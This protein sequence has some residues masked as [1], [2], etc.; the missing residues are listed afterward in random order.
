MSWVYLPSACFQEPGAL[1]L[2]PDGAGY[3]R[4]AMSSGTDTPKPSSCP[5]SETS[6]LTTPQYGTTLPLSTASLGAERWISSLAGF[7]ASPIPSPENGGGHQTNATYGPIRC[8]YCESAG[9]GDSSG[10]MSQESLPMDL[11]PR[12][13]QTLNERV[14]AGLPFQ[15][16]LVPLVPHTHGNECFSWPTP[17]KTDCHN[18][19]WGTAERLL[20]GFKS[21]QSGAQIGAS[22]KWEPHLRWLKNG[23]E[24][25]KACLNPRFTEQLMD[26]PTGWT[27]LDAA[28]T[29]WYLS[30]R[31]PRSRGSLSGPIAAVRKKWTPSNLTRVS[32][33]LEKGE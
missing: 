3:E 6:S 20:A 29:E 7:P 16:Q 5:E 24:K 12:S 18:G 30:K 15:I 17:A 13:W 26:W 11:P 19:S 14:S 23:G 33:E 21:R 22:L 27:E 25:F 1:I 8:E 28:A 9:P 10:K 31:F 2:R 32:R 4:S